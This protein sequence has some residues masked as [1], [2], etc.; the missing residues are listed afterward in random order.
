MIDYITGTVTE[1]NPACVVVECNGIGYSINISL[2]TYTALDKAVTCKILIHES[3]REDAHLLY[4]FATAG[5]RDLF[6]QLITVSGVG[7]GTARMMLSSVTPS[8]LRE[9]IITGDTAILKAIKG[10]GL[11]TAQRII[12]DLK[13]KIGKHAGSGEIL[14]F[15]DNTA[16]EEALSALVMLGFARSSATKVIDNILRENRKLQVEEIVRKALKLL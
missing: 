14:A 13:D 10:I 15:S 16:R 8:D 3:I 11:K 1:L 2:N 9:A 12:V 6:R 5:E 4:G 7:A